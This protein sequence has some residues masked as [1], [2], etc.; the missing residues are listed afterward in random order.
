M[1]EWVKGFSVGIVSGLV[2]V[3]L[4]ITLSNQIDHPKKL[5]VG[6]VTESIGMEIHFE[7]EWFDGFR[8]EGEKDIARGA[9]Y[10]DMRF[11]IDGVEKDMP[12]REFKLRMGVQ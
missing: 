5:D 9:Y 6:T 4:S 10:T 12:Y 2:G 3:M 7:K 11:I 1:Q 8:K